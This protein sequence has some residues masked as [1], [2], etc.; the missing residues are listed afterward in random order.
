LRQIWNLCVRT[1]QYGVQEVIQDCMDREKGFYMGDGC[2]TALTNMV[3]TG[4]DRIV[5]K[6]L[7]D[8]FAT[9]FISEGLMTCLD[10]S[11]MQ[12]IAEYPLMLIDLCLWH[13]RF[14]KDKDYLKQNCLKARAVLESYRS[15]YEKDGLLSRLD[16][17][18]V[19]EWPKNYQ[20]GYDVD[21]QEGKVCE[22]AHVSI[23]A[24][25]LEAIMTLNKANKEA[26]LSAYRDEKPLQEAFYRAFYD[27]ETHLFRDGIHTN[28]KSYIG[29]IFPFAFGLIP[30]P[31]FLETFLPIAEEKGLAGTSFFCGFLLLKGYTLLGKEENVIAC[32]KEQGTYARML[33]E[34]ATA[35]FEGWGKDC[36]WNT[37]LF[38]LTL[39]YGA[40]FLA[41]IPLKKI[42]S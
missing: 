17:W 33:S 8:G 9:S 14:T 38:H 18:C 20:D 16:K 31:R 4:D 34:G 11:M 42:L 3:L 24:Y 21:I 37:S 6:L 13:F 5:R 25:Y 1:Q 28:H 35:T 39:S 12:E 36:K 40:L 22:E 2:Y 27:K 32:L 23:N 26:G 29:N 19:V 15:L 10:C 41:D 30:E 7:D